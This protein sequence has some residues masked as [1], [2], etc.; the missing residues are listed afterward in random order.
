MKI[1]IEVEDVTLFVDALN[2]AIA[3]YGNI[4]VAIYLYCDIPKNLEKLKEVSFD[5][6]QK[7]FDCIKNV[8]DQALA[9]EKEKG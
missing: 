7:R 6:L 1:E 3:T 9:I 2:N 8:Y 5:K 4:L